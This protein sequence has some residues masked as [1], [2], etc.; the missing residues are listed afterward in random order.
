MVDFEQLQGKWQPHR[1]VP[2]AWHLEYTTEYVQASIVTGPRGSGLMACNDP[3]KPTTY[4]VWFAGFE[5]PTGYLT[6]DGLVGAITVL[7]QRAIEDNMY[8]D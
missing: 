7:E 3:G 5:D 1:N 8:K 2:G 4:E 6:F